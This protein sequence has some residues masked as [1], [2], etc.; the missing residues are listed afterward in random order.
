MVLGGRAQTCTFFLCLI[1][2]LQLARGQGVWSGLVNSPRGDFDFEC[3]N[4]TVIVG[5]AS[6][7]RWVV[8]AGGGV[9][10]RSVVHSG[11][12][13]QRVAL[14]HTNFTDAYTSV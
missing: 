2:L 1:S 8:G 6:V 14:R 7:F 12:E 9:M 10:A 13:T 4:S 3:A 11:G 5:L